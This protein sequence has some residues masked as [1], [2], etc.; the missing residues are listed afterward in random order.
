MV[1]LGSAD[2][3]MK[4]AHTRDQIASRHKILAFEMEAAGIIN[5]CDALVIRGVCD[6]ADTHK[7]DGW[8]NF[9]AVAAAAYAKELL[10]VLN[11][12]GGPRENR[13]R[14]RGK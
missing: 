5:V 7:N 14:A 9:A 4:N 12:P 11:D 6:Y 3:V 1:P 13:E 2:I 10:C 8:H